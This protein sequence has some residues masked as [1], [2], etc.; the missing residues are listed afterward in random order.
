MNKT[1]E[2]RREIGVFL[3]PC[4]LKKVQWTFFSNVKGICESS[5]AIC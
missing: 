2:T 3:L 5:K 4:M 1:S